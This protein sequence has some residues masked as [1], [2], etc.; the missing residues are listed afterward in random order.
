MLT[1]SIPLDSSL[2]CVIL[3]S[4]ADIDSEV[5]HRLSCASGAYARLRR[6]VFEDQ[7]LSAQTKLLVYSC[8]PH[9]AVWSRVMDHLQQASESNGTIPSE[10][11]TKD[12]VDQLEGQTH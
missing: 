9:P 12:S 2:C 6:R 1:N 10:I 5:N 11:L 3:S 8:P 7:D 4:K